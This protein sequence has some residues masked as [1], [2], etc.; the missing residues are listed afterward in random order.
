MAKRRSAGGQIPLEWIGAVG[1]LTD[2]ATNVLLALDLNLDD[3]EMAEILTIDSDI[4][5][6]LDAD[7]VAE[8]ETLEGNLAL[9]M[10]P[11]Y[12]VTNNPYSETVYED[13]ETFF[14][15]GFGLDTGSISAASQFVFANHNNKQARFEPGFGIMLANNP[16]ALVSCPAITG[17][18]TAAFHIRV[19]FKRRKATD[20]QL[21]R[22]L[23]KRR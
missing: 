16:A 4:H 1:T 8:E 18:S 22:T 19:Y 21:A 6:E 5:L 7:T 23:L 11:S 17:T 9:V 12:A 3:D 13:L 2:A 15:H 14:N 20:M 10:D